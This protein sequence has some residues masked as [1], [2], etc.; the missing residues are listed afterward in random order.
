[1][2]NLSLDLGIREYG[3]PG[4]VIR[5]NPADPNVYGRFL[6]LQPKLE[7]VQTAFAKKS[8]GCKEGR[9][10][11]ALLQEADSQLKTLLQEV[12]PGNDFHAALGGMNLLAVNGAGKTAAQ[13]LLE[14][15]E[16]ILSRGAKTLV[17][18]EAKKLKENA[19]YK[20]Q[21]A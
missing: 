7:A 15:L 11:L 5:F 9:Q 10:V 12:F 6:D 16:G 4:G 14:G 1:M 13:V 21:N 20:V 19:E 3:L 17:E 18:Q 2:E 8:R